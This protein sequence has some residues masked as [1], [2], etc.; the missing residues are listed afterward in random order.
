MKGYTTVE[1][2]E[3][4]LLIT[5]EEYFKPQVEE[6]IG[7]VEKMI[8]RITERESFVPE[9]GRQA[10]FNGAG[11]RI[12]TPNS[13]SLGFTGSF[14][15]EFDIVFDSL[16][17]YPR[18]LVKHNQDETQF[19]WYIYYQTD[20]QTLLMGM[21]GDGGSVEGEISWV[22]TLGVK[23][24]V[25]INYIA[26][27]SHWELYVNDQFVGD[28]NTLL[29][30]HFGNGNILRI[31][32]GENSYNNSFAGKI[33]ELKIRNESQ[34]LVL[35]YSFD[36]DDAK[37]DSLYGN[38]GA[39]NEV[40][41][42]EGGGYLATE[43]LFDGDGTKILIIPDCI[44]VSKVEIDGEELDPDVPDYYLYPAN[45]TPKRKIELENRRFTK[46]KQNITVKAAWAYSEEAPEDI[47]FAATVIAAGVINA[48]RS[49]GE[50][51]VRSMTIGRYSVTYDNEKGWDDFKRA[52]EILTSYKRYTM[53]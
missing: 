37:D 34:D 42:E 44:S 50:G 12:D 4:Y 45:E 21:S 2:I 11:S 43:R 28:N 32:K 14:S 39:M 20:N 26:S 25:K 15:L 10:V 38:D 41:F 47:V 31:G 19:D 6:W 3:N 13:A 46:G 9:T 24:H 27:Q 18:L 29:D 1:K 49:E 40:T 33:D 51:T 7:Q 35:F 53:A 16:D 17:N 5:I 30:S 8:D 36:N 52:N 48:S 22:P 23:Y